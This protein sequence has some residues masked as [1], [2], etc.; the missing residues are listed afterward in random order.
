MVQGLK[1][2]QSHRILDEFKSPR[3][4]DC[5]GKRAPDTDSLF[6]IYLG[7]QKVIIIP[8]AITSIPPTMIGNVGRERNAM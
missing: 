7:F 6:K 1:K 5:Y 3:K 8:P 4:I 2:N